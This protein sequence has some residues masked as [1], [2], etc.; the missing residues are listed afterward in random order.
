VEGEYKQITG[1]ISI[2]VDTFSESPCLELDYKLDGKPINYK[3]DLVN[4][5]SNIGKGVVWFFVCPMTGKKCRKLYL[6]DTYFT[7]RSF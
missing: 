3:V 4:V 7:S 5:P 1:S 6:V 2:A